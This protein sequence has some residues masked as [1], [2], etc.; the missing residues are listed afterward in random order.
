MVGI[1][2]PGLLCLSGSLGA[3]SLATPNVTTAQ[4]AEGKAA[5]QRSCA[6]CQGANLDDGVPTSDVRLVAST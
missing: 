4:A 5:Y 2:L 6:S 3:Q 1:G